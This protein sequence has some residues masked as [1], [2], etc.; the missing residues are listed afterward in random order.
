META[1]TYTHP[2]LEHFLRFHLG[3]LSFDLKGGEVAWT[4]QR[5]MVALMKKG[6]PFPDTCLGADVHLLV[7][8]AVDANKLTLM[9]A[10]GEASATGIT[11]LVD[12]TLTD[13]ENNRKR[14]YGPVTITSTDNHEA[15]VAYYDNAVRSIFASSVVQTLFADPATMKTSWYGK[16]NSFDQ[17]KYLGEIINQ[18]VALKGISTLL[19]SQL[20]TSR[21]ASILIDGARS[22]SLAISL[23]RL[24]NPEASDRLIFT[25]GFV[26]F[27]QHFGVLFNREQAYHSGKIYRKQDESTLAILASLGINDGG[28]GLLPDIDV[29]L[30][31]VLRILRYNPESPEKQGSDPT[32]LYNCFSVTNHIVATFFTEHKRVYEDGEYIF[33]LNP[34]YGH[35]ERTMEML[36]EVFSDNSFYQFH[37]EKIKRFI[38]NADR[39]YRLHIRS[40]MVDGGFVS[41]T[42]IQAF[43]SK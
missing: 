31:E 36:N 33:K 13:H 40:K 2:T 17:K 11:F 20:N 6:F 8:S 16:V 34:S 7:E 22:A 15:C 24:L 29:D 10:E 9:C 37:R 38:Y 5:I 23:V 28:E 12:K 41:G 4:S 32:V 26:C 35:V 27:V 39:Y 1:A 14:A 25:I 42:Q 43:Q 3:P 21:G 19:A 30:E 18:L